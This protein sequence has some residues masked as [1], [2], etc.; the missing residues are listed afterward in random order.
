MTPTEFILASLNFVPGKIYAVSGQDI[1]KVMDLLYSAAE[2]LE[3]SGVIVLV[4]DFRCRPPGDLTQGGCKTYLPDGVYLPTR[5]HHVPETQSILWESHSI[6]I[7]ELTDDGTPTIVL[8]GNEFDSTSRRMNP[9]PIS[10][11]VDVVRDIM[12][13]FNVKGMMRARSNRFSETREL[14]PYLS[15]IFYYDTNTE[16]VTLLKQQARYWPENVGASQTLIIGSPLAGEQFEKGKK[17]T[18]VWNSS[19]FPLG[20]DLRIE[21]WK[22]GASLLELAKT[23]PD[24][25]KFE[26]I[27]PAWLEA[28]VDYS[29]KLQ[30][31][32]D[33]YTVE[34]LSSEFEVL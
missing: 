21:L 13:P 2:Q 14:F 20:A 34:S 11:E 23:T 26:W 12:S 4:Y 10:I 8:I 16:N 3:L 30:L 17:L 27:I 9:H 7:Q 5:Y 6:L 18:V 24:D 25:G 19:D 22:T 29:V 32:N 33:D 28:G 31:L 1:N 15:E